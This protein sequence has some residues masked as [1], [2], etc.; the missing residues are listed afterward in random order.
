MAERSSFV[1]VANRLPVDEVTGPDGE[2]QWRPSP[3]G[4]VTALHP[5]LAEHRGTW[6]GWAGGDGRAPEP[7]ELDGIHIHPVPLSA[8]RSSSATTRASP[9]PRSGRSTT[10]RSRPPVYKRRWREAYRRGQP[11]VRPRPP[12][13]SPTRARP[14]GCRTTSCNW[15]RRCSASCGPTCGSASSCT[16]RS[17]RS[18]CSCSCRAAPRSC[19]ACSAPTWSASSSRLAAQNFVRLARHLLG[20]RYEGQSIQV[21]RPQGQGRRVPDQH[22]HGRAWNGWPP[23]REVQAR[24][25]EIRAELGDP[26]DGH[27]RRRP[28]RL[29]QGHRAAPQGVPRTAGRRPAERAGRG[30]G[31]GRHAQPGTRR[32]LPDAA[33]ARSSAR[34]AGSTA[35]SAGSARPRCTTCTSRTA[36]RTGRAVRRG[37]RHDGHAAARR[38]E[39]GRQGVRGLPRRQRRCAGAQRV[40]RAPPPSCGRRSCATR[41]T[42]TASRTRCCARLPPSRRS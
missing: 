20:L 35:S 33:G 27:P 13:R 9:T 41:T 16:S 42:R 23:T 21:R 2:R 18:S 14:S 11:A 38:H 39:P 10:T 8:P 5:V 3:G 37:R 4:L 32:A 25:K 6:I 7:F 31:A 36:G 34:S 1:V 26:Q 24:A 30:D 22:R 40:R 17:R 15:C 29:H 28:A 19:A 12:P